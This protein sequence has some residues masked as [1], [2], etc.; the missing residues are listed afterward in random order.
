[1]DFITVADTLQVNNLAAHSIPV[2][3]LHW[4]RPRAC[5][6]KLVLWAVLDAV[7]AY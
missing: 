6:H 5:Q 7:P 2:L 1:M 4:R 3:W